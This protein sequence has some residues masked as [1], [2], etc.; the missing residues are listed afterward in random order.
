MITKKCYVVGSKANSSLSP[1]IFNYWFNQ[2]KVKG[3][4]KPLQITTQNFN[5]KIKKT[6]SEENLCGLNITIPFKEK[7]IKHLSKSDKH[8][9]KIQ[10]VN[11]VTKNK[12]QINGTNTDWLG[13]INSIKYFE[14][15]RKKRIKRNLAIV[16]GYGGSAKAIIYALKKLRF[17]KIT[18]VNRTF[19][20]I[21]NLKKVSPIQKKQLVHLAPNADLIINTVP[22]KHFIKKIFSTNKTRRLSGVGYDIVYKPNTGFLAHFHKEKKINGISLLVHQAEPCFYKWFRIKPI[23]DDKIFAHLNRKTKRKTWQK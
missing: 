10:A 20:K 9:K 11:C 16:I 4:Y 14:K 22:N 3:S 7:I 19:K 2:H 8:T 21:K 12:K 23:I 13:L 1:K 6:L 15:N 17:K 5:K 18:V